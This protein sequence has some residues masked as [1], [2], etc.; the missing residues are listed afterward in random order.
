MILLEMA[1][2]PS[3]HS[4]APDAFGA[5]LLMRVPSAPLGIAVEGWRKEESVETALD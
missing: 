5:A 1:E 2:L 4:L 3:P